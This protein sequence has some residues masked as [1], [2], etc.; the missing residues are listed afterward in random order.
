MICF[1]CDNEE[2]KTENS[3]IEQEFGGHVIA[4]EVPASFCVMCGWRTLTT[5]QADELFKKT[6]AAYL[7]IKAKQF[8][9]PD[10]VV[11]A[12]YKSKPT[13]AIATLKGCKA[14][15]SPHAARDQANQTKLENLFHFLETFMKVDQLTAEA[16][17]THHEENIDRLESNLDRL[18]LENARLKQACELVLL[19]YT[20]GPWTYD[21]SQAWANGLTELLGCAF[22]RDS[23]IVGVNGDGTW[24]KAVPTNEASTKNLCNAVRAALRS[25]TSPTDK[26][27]EGE[28]G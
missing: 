27:S 14:G 19:F 9:R 25:I 16:T 12:R 23:K 2:F 20:V 8:D 11:G 10:P 26:T 3:L 4:V 21:K 1:S 17:I 18:R 5:N 24:D 7:T 13:G 6:I 28:K 15:W 22:S